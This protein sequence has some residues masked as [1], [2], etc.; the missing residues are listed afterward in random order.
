MHFKQFFVKEEA[1]EETKVN[2]ENSQLSI[3]ASED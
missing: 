3:E 2:I 1:N